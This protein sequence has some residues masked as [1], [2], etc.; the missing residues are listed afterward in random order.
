[1]RRR[2]RDEIAPS[3]MIYFPLLKWNLTQFWLQISIRFLLQIK[4]EE[5]LKRIEFSQSGT[6]QFE[7][8]WFIRRIFL[9]KIA[10]DEKCV[11]VREFFW[12]NK[13][14]FHIPK[15]TKTAE[16]KQKGDYFH[17]QFSHNKTYLYENQD[18]SKPNW[19]HDFRCLKFD[20][21]CLLF[22]F[23]WVDTF[24]TILSEPKI[25]RCARGG[26]GRASP[27]LERKFWP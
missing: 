7:F 22:R 17:Q 15:L 1:M 9:K 13:T 16:R 12:A 20:T 25:H 5:A 6:P 18:F 23:Y 4:N 10:V 24:L 2:R 21:F 26:P 11:L 14:H 8:Q 19:P 3:L 27:P